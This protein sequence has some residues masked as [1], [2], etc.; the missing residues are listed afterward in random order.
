MGWLFEKYGKIKDRTK[1]IR[2]LEVFKDVGKI[3][4]DIS[5]DNKFAKAQRKAMRR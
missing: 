2:N 3:A 1:G 4:Y 5:K